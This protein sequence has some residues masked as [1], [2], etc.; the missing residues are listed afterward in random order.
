[1]KLFTLTCLFFVYAY[2]LQAQT[3]SLSRPSL[4]YTY[5]LKLNQ[6][7]LKPMKGHL[8]ELKDSSLVFVNRFNFQPIEYP[9]GQIDLLTYRKKNS[10]LKGTLIGLAGGTLLGVIIGFALGDD[11]CDGS[12]LFGGTSS[13]FYSYTAGE[14]ALLGGLGGFFYGAAFGAIIGSTTIKI[15]IKGKQENYRFYKPTFK[16]N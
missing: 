15:P 2:F 13:C 16:F 14:K 10:L 3:D 1:M 8:S 6:G 7:E 5:F 11:Q 9:I 4:K 12:G